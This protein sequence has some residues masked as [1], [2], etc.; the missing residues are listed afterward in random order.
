MLT[1]LYQSTI[2]SPNANV[3]NQLT[4]ND[5]LVSDVVGDGNFLLRAI[6]VCFYGIQFHH[7]VLWKAVADY[8]LAN[9][10]P[11]FCSAQPASQDKDK[12]QGVHFIRMEGEWA[13]ENALVTAAYLLQRQIQV[14]TSHKS[15]PLTYLPLSNVTCSQFQP[16]KLAF[17]EP[18]HY[19]PVDNLPSSKLSLN[20]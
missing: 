11:L 7:A 8:L 20:Q 1:S 6:S 5:L 4:L 17:Y 10:E 2:R 13:G 16:I 14:F 19:Q 15:S 18:W 3:N 9:F 12:I